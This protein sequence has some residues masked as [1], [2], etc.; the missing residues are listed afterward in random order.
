MIKLSCEACGNEYEKGSDRGH[1]NRV[2]CRDCTS[3]DIIQDLRNRNKH[4]KRVYGITYLQYK[5][6]FESQGGKCK[7]CERQLDEQPQQ[8]K[9]GGRRSG[10]EPVI[11]HCHHTDKVRGI[12]CFHCNVALGHVN[13]SVDILSKML[14]YL[15]QD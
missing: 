1:N 11:D 2:F 8:T 15:K 6:L 13:D 3:S 9:R 7:I 5:D 10:G 14:E 4:M 12:L